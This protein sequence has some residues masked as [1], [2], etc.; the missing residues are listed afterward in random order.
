MAGFLAAQAAT[1]GPVPFDANWKEQGFLRLFSNDYSLQGRKLGVTSDG[2]VSLLWRPVGE[3]A[4]QTGGASWR[5]GVTNGVAATD[6]TRKGSDDRNLAL[7]FIFV[8]PARAEALKTR[9]ARAILREDSARALIYVW[10]GA[11]QRG[12]VLPSPYSP[13][14]KTVV[15]RPSGTGDHRERV[16]LA[17]DF[18]R[19]F[20]T[21]PGALLGLA[22]SADSDDT[23]GRISGSISD[24]TLE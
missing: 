22:V 5:W 6:L 7:Y 18:R 12:N 16:D 1:A 10:G 8:D 9:S 15:L 13:R 24:L 19:A 17:K 14:L 4:R 21:A 3:D 23:K 2:T 11:H 20:G